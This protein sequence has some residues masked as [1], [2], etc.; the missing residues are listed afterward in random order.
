[1]GEE[2]ETSG[3]KSY[4]VVA[5]LRLQAGRRGHSRGK[6]E[7]V[8]SLGPQSA[9]DGSLSCVRVLPAGQPLVE[10]GVGI[11]DLCVWLFCVVWRFLCGLWSIVGGISTLWSII[12]S[13]S[14]L[15]VESREAE[16]PLTPPTRCCCCR[17]M[18]TSSF[19]TEERVV[20]GFGGLDRKTV[21]YSV[22]GMR[23]RWCS[24]LLQSRCVLCVLA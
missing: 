24:M 15:S 16:C 18:A 19:Y 13:F 7:R 4:Q 10:W 2:T 17:V 22:P 12:P 9:S 6:Q 23:G 5:F 14:R 21:V 1:M 11:Y 3:K 20:L 8:T